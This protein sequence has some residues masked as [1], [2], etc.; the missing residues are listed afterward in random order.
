MIC[1]EFQ[2]LLKVLKCFAGHYRYAYIPAQEPRIIGH[3]PWD[4]IYWLSL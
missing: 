3:Y 2:V 1:E 4:S